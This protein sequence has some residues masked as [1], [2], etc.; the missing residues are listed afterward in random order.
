MKIFSVCL[1]AKTEFCR[2]MTRIANAVKPLRI[3]RR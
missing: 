1:K 3:A 2:I